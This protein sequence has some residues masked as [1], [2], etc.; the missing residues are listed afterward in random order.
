MW[1]PA[2]PR[3]KAARAVSATSACSFGRKKTALFTSSMAATVTTSAPQPNFSLAT[4]ILASIGSQGN[5]ATRRPSAVSSPR[6]FS[7][8]SA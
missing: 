3:A 1:S 4:I 6:S 7:A 5:S 8:P 2:A